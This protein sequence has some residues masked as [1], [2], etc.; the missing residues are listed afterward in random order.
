MGKS[1]MVLDSKARNWRHT[2]HCANMLAEANLTYI[3][4][5]T[6]SH[7]KLGTDSVDCIIGDWTVFESIP[8]ELQKGAGPGSEE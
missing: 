2:I 4:G 8:A 3:G 1:P 5:R 6:S 7:A